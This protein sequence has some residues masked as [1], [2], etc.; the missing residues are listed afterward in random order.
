MCFKFLPIRSIVCVFGYRM[1]RVYFFPI[2]LTVSFDIHGLCFDVTVT[3]LFGM[4]A[5]ILGLMFTWHS[6]R[7]SLERVSGAPICTHDHVGNISHY[8][9]NA[10]SLVACLM[11]Y[12]LPVPYDAVQTT[13]GV[14]DPA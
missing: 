4:C 1:E 11:H 6:I 2:S 5:G 7:L 10:V 13:T 12:L 8:K 3:D 14:Y 9:V